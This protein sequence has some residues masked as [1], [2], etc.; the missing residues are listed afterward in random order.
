MPSAS[1]ADTNVSAPF[2]PARSIPVNALSLYFSI[3]A[4]VI[5]PIIGVSQ[6]S[7]CSPTPTAL[8]AATV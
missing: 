7:D 8:L 6:T 1:V 4:S 5:E 2:P 3:F